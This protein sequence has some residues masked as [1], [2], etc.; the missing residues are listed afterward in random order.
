MIVIHA[1][2]FTVVIEVFSST[3]EM[4]LVK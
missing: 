2:K 4:L 3:C 1:G